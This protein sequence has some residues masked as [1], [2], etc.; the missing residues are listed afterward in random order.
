GRALAGVATACIDVSDGLVADLGHVCAA[1]GVGA[2]LDIDAL[3]GGELLRGHLPA[4]DL[5]ALQATGGDDYELCFTLPA[6]SGATA[7]AVA[8]AA[9]AGVEVTRV[10][11]V[12]EGQGVEAFDRN[13]QPWQP[14]SPGHQH[15]A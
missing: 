11:V 4:E 2:R 6:G 3:P 8:T 9:A 7:A 14:A 1:S 13:G 12:V 15:F 10:G 5:R